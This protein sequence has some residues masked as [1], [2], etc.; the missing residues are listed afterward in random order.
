MDFV[1]ESALCLLLRFSIGSLSGSAGICDS[2][3]QIILFLDVFGHNWAIF[4]IS[5]LVGAHINLSNDEVPKSD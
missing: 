1:L 5:K 2:E 4:L 3:K